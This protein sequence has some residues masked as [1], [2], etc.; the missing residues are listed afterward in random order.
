MSR[1]KNYGKIPAKWMHKKAVITM[2]P[3]LVSER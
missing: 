1:E 3:V 2:T